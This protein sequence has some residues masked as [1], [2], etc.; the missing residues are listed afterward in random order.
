MT[1]ILSGGQ[2]EFRFYR[3]Q[4]SEVGIAGTFN[5][6]QS[7]TAPMRRL[8]D[9][10][11]RA[12]LELPAGEYQFRY[13]ADGQWYTDFAA[14]GVEHSRHALNS[15]LVIHESAIRAAA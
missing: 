1:N 12:V 11:W 4:A 9:G 3:P 2:V 15:V 7:K 10:W 8:G 13:V 5:G 6:W 14:H